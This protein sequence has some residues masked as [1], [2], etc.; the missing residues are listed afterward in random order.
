MSITDV[1]DGATIYLLLLVEF[2]DTDIRGVVNDVILVSIFFGEGIPAMRFC[3]ALLAASTIK[4]VSDFLLRMCEVNSSFSSPL[5][6]D[7]VPPIREFTSLFSLTSLNG[8]A[9]T[10]EGVAEVSIGGR[11]TEE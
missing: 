9:P 8:L 1:F 7:S 6:P 10:R 3:L 4:A 2:L 11:L 5:S